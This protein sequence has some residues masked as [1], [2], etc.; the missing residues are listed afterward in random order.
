MIYGSALDIR[1]AVEGGVAE[2]IQVVLQMAGSRET[3]AVPMFPDPGG[4][5][6]A[7]LGS[8][9]SAGTYCLQARGARSHRYAIDLVTVPRIAGVRFRITPPAYAN[10]PAYEGPLPQGGIS[11]LAGTRV[12]LWI[13]SNR[14]LASGSLQLAAIHDG[15]A[16]MPATVPAS[17]PTTSPSQL[18]LTPTGA[19]SSEVTGAFTIDRNTK[20]TA[21]VMDLAGQPSTD[22]FSAP[23]VLVPDGRPF[24]RVM[25]PPSL[26][27]ATPD[28]IVPVNL[29]A[30]DD[31]GISRLQL[32]RSLNDS[33]VWPME[34]PLTQR[35]QARVSQVVPLK[36]AD[37]ALSP[38][39]VVKVFAR[40]Q[41]NDPAG[42]KGAETSITVIRIVSQ[43]EMQ[44]LAAA[45]EGLES[46]L[47]KYDQASRRLEAVL[48]RLAKIEDDLAKLDPKAD[49]PDE[50][51][52]ALEQLSGQ[53]AKDAVEI[54]KAAQHKL[55]FD[56]DKALTGELDKAAQAMDESA[57]TAEG[58][59]RAL[60][61]SA[62]QIKAGVAELRK[63]LDGARQGYEKEAAQPL[64]HLAKV[65]PLIE[66]EAAFVAIYERQRD[67]ADR[68]ASLR[69]TKG[70]DDPSAKSRMRD[71]EEEQRRIRQDLDELLGS[72]ERHAAEL[73]EDA[74]LIELRDSAKRFAA[75]V[76]ESNAGK[77]M[78]AA[79]NAL[80][81][82]DGSPAHA[83]AKDAADILQRF[84]EQAGKVGNQAAECLKFQP[85]L[86]GALGRTVEQLLG[87]E[88]GRGEGS[89]GGGYSMRQHTLRNVGLYGRQ[90]SPMASAKSGSGTA[91][92]G[93]AGNAGAEQPIPSGSDV[94]P[95]PGGRAVGE[96]AAAVPPQY[97]RRVSDYFQRVADELEEK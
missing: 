62:G 1:A 63:K 7:T 25:E 43:E 36:L 11:G 12:Q 17:A 48:Q 72:I 13:T 8:V 81:D 94:S 46:L 34:V 55:P 66:D 51:R 49:V 37:Y 92:R 9:T 16:T 30:E 52:Q 87:G 2:D 71:L 24:V 90:A 44:S 93:A 21:S 3:E 28:A 47:A 29:M 61:L 78:A 73:P 14:P 82:F 69:G 89:R 95:G 86:A 64:E 5:W 4:K 50:L 53:M 84:L 96:S 20:L 59:A 85:R 23:V 15:P 19:A 33:R 76:K 88:A 80:T 54:A 39:D 41:D 77:Q 10:R 67:L 97:R 83:A 60:A 38:G 32:Y 74:R 26:S 70:E 68:M 75:A 22:S 65:Y 79:E 56:I 35:A 27:L 42:A 57:K 18:A 31:C 40:A 91:R 45:Q 58:L 6:R